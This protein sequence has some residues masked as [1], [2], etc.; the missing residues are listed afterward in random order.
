MR[1]SSIFDES[2]CEEGENKLKLTQGREK[3][4]WMKQRSIGKWSRT[5]STGLPHNVD[6]EREVMMAGG[7]E[8]GGVSS[9][10]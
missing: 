3:T 6:S 8:M 4:V 9:A 7:G 10:E 5:Y 2:G 1:T